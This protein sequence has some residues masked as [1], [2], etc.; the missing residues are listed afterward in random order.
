MPGKFFSGGAAGILNFLFHIGCPTGSDAAA[1]EVNEGGDG[2]WGGDFAGLNVPGGG[3]R[4]GRALEGEH[5]M[6]GTGEG[7]DE[8]PADQA[9]GAGD[10]N[11]WVV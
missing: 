8:M 7:G 4:S 2:L 3:A 1:G 6:A 9:G 5:R 11:G 10:G